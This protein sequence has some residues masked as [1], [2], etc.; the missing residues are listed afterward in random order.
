MAT[1]IFGGWALGGIVTFQSGM[2][3]S[4]SLAGDN[5]RVGGGGPQ[6]PNLV[7]DPNDGPK[8]LDQWFNTA[9]FTQPARGTF[10][11]SAWANIRLPGLTNFDLT[12][13][14][15]VQISER[16]GLQVRGEFFNAF[17][18]PQW[19]GV[20]LGFNNNA[21]GRVTSAHDPRIM[22]IGMKFTF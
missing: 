14:K 12:L 3:G 17:N 21:F 13:S 22:Q 10:G 18:H 6:R 11:N 2:M 4:A 7:D 15:T 5:G 1:K 16:V 8:T 9:A 20:A 19:R